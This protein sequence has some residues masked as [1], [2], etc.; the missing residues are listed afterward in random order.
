MGNNADDKRALTEKRRI[1]MTRA[2]VEEV[3]ARQM[4]LQ[5]T[6]EKKAAKSALD[7]ARSNAMNRATSEE[8]AA[9]QST[10]SRRSK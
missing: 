1:A 5:R 3:S 2:V 4:V 6:K 7:K 8:A 10:R 9:R